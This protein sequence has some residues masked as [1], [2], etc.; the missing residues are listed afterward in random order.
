MTQVSGH[1]LPVDGPAARFPTSL[2]PHTVRG[3]HVLAACGCFSLTTELWVEGTWDLPKI[4]DTSLECSSLQQARVIGNWRVQ[5][6]SKCSG[7]QKL[8]LH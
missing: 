3:K 1:S 7:Y 4:Q 8:K 2:W 6:Q 5:R